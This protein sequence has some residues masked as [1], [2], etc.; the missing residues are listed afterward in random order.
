MT[1][2]NKAWP[3][4]AGLL[5]S[6]LCQA[7]RSRWEEVGFPLQ[8]E[9]VFKSLRDFQLLY[10]WSRGKKVVWSKSSREAFPWKSSSSWQQPRWPWL[11]DLQVRENWARIHSKSG[12]NGPTI[13][14]TVVCP[15]WGWLES[16]KKHTGEGVKLRIPVCWRCRQRQARQNTFIWWSCCG[17]GHGVIAKIWFTFGK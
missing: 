7:C 8:T 12:T 17:F 11:P 9:S 5:C 16:D 15:L 6:G 2:G 1:G 10:L 3:F 13:V 4:S 14:S